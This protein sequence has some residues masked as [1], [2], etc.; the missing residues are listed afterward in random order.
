MRGLGSWVIFL[1]LL[2][3]LSSFHDRLTFH[4]RSAIF[5][6]AAQQPVS[7]PRP[8]SFDHVAFPEL[9]FRPSFRS[10]WIFSQQCKLSVHHVCADTDLI[11]ESGFSFCWPVV[12]KFVWGVYQRVCFCFRKKKKWTG[13]CTLWSLGGSSKWRGTFFSSSVSCVVNPP[14]SGERPGLWRGGTHNLFLLQWVL[15]STPLHA[16]GEGRDQV[17]DAVE[18]M[19]FFFF[20]EF[21]C[22]P[23]P[24]PAASGEVTGYHLCLLSLLSS[25]HDRLTFHVPPAIFTT[26]KREKERGKHTQQVSD[27]VT[28]LCE[29]VFFPFSSD[30]CRGQKNKPR[31]T[32]I[33]NRAWRQDYR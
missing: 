26:A 29:L 12:P 5:T 21:C 1:C 14:A 27:E 31:T 23:P 13:R 9:L 16:S 7:N 30:V 24:P 17:F 25:F 20:S 28:Y 18:P 3:L 8:V 22:R 19:V 32:I 2:P 6:N 15:L 11:L 4:V 10:S 33:H